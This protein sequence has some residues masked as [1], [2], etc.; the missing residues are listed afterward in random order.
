MSI[1]FD[2]PAARVIKEFSGKDSEQFRIPVNLPDITFLRALSVQGRLRY[3]QSSDLNA[4][5]I[6]IVPPTGETFFFYRGEF[7]QTAGANGDVSITNNGN[8]RW[9]MELTQVS[10]GQGGLN[11]EFIDSLVGDGIKSFDVEDDAA[12]SVVHASV[13]GWVEN[14][15]RIRDVSI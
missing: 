1:E 9:L 6:S 2:T 14:T 7:S 10:L 5:P 8:I 3:F 13:F 11:T 12:A 4:N 15:S